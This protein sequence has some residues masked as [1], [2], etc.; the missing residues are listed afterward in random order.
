MYIKDN[1]TGVQHLGIPVVDLKES[2]KWYEEKLGFK[3]IFQKTVMFH[4][5]FEAAFLQLKDLTLELY[6]VPDCDLSDIIHR[7]TGMIDHFSI[8]TADLDE[9]ADL[10]YNRGANLS[11]NTPDGPVFLETIG[12][13]GVRF[14]CFTGPNGEIIELN[15]NYNVSYNGKTGLLGWS[16]L[17]IKVTDMKRSISF[18]E[19]LGFQKV[20]DGY[21][22]NNAEKQAEITFIELKG[23]QIELIMPAGRAKTLTE[24]QP[25]HIDHIALD[26]KDARE[27][28]YE[29]KK[30]GFSLLN[31]TLTELPFFAHGVRFFMVEGP[32][33]EKIEFSQI[34]RW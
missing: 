19:K 15:Q 7:S 1:I 11:S 25:G 31:Y 24:Y 9:Y 16:H 26:V 20:M 23:F 17:A 18:Y 14:V 2:V 32:D 33:G 29:L 10:I 28:F 22:Y 21:L 30:E 3:N 4:G 5:K 12:E 13:N 6:R 8:D 27:A 34:I